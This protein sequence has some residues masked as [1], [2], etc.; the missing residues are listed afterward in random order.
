MAG[1]SSQSL[2]ED[3]GRE[4]MTT[5]RRPVSPI[6]FARRVE[7]EEGGD[8]SAEAYNDTFDDDEDDA[9]LDDY[10][11][12][13]YLPPRTAASSAAVDIIPKAT[14]PSSLPQYTLLAFSTGQILED[15]YQLSW[16]SVYP[17]E[18]LEL[19]P[20]A[21]LVRLPRD[22]IEDYAKP[23]F[24][25]RVW[26]LK[27]ISEETVLGVPRTGDKVGRGVDSADHERP[28]KKK[29]LQWQES[30]VA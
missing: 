6:T 11:K 9:L 26:A 28:R 22:N 27:V 3:L 25:A 12:F 16:Y 17:H 10:D 20:H 18:L 4:T 23:Y 5:K 2:L 21:C 1:H 29:K 15:H 30:V 19:H 13:K 24:E 14:S 8:L 7:V